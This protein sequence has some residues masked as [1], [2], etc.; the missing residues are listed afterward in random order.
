MQNFEQLGAFYLGKEFDLQA[1]Q[2]SDKLVMYDSRDL[3]THA[4]CLGMTGSGKTGLCVTLLEEAAI[5]GIPAIIIDPKGDITNLLLT[6]PDLA[7]ESFEPWINIEDAARKG[8]EPS[9]YAGH[10]AET[11]RKGL[12]Q[13]GQSQDRISLLRKSADFCIYTPGS[14]AGLPISIVASF[15]APTLDWDD[16]EELLREQIQ[17]TVS[18]LLGLVGVEADPLRSRE[19]I[20]LATLFEY[21]WRQ[22]QDLSLETLI[23]AIQKPPIRRLGVLEVDTFFPEKDRFNLAMTLNNII[24]APSFSSWTQGEPLDIAALLHTRDGKPR[25]SIFYIAHL[26]DAER[27]FFVT[28]LLE[29]LLSWVRRQSGTTSLRALLYFDE[30]FGYFPPISNPPSKKPMLTLLKQ[31]RA[32]GLGLMVCTQNPMDLDYKGLA[33]TGT[34]FIG[35]LQTDRDKIRVLDGLQSVTTEAGGGFDRQQLDEL[36]SSLGNRVFLLHNVHETEPLVFQTRWALSYLR[37]PLTRGQVRK[38]MA[39]R[40]ADNPAQAE[41]VTPVSPLTQAFSHSVVT[42]PVDT[43]K[44]TLPHDLTVGYLPLNQLNELIAK[45]PSRM[46]T[47]VFG[48]SPSDFRYLPCA[49]ILER[50]TVTDTRYRINET[51]TIGFLVHP[52]QIAPVILWDQTYRTSLDPRHLTKDP[53]PGIR[54]EA[55]PA[56]FNTVRK[57]QSLAKDASD[58]IYREHSVNLLTAPNLKLVSQAEEDER[59]FR[60]RAQQTARENR[61][62]EIDKLRQSYQ[63]KLD[64][65]QDRLAAARLDFTEDQANYERKKRD[66]LISTGEAILGFLGVLG[67]GRKG[68]IGSVLSKSGRSGA[69]RSALEKTEQKIESLENDITQL[70]EELRDEVAAISERWQSAV[71][72][73]ETL[74]IK[75]RRSDIQVVMTALVW[76]PQPR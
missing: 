70:T 75:P 39:H 9:E 64:R 29:Q 27:M 18:G 57:L 4:V 67:R 44:P 6:F 43:E 62:D 19:H 12:A 40:K 38:L 32:F 8:M 55:V 47:Q 20:L 69:A 3:T 60:A 68:R 54:H 21:F 25:H 53:E 13:W 10:I 49:Y 34:W 17:G 1:N 42:E 66:E 5:D 76:V 58:F 37:G 2:P 46:F 30:V 73:I 26:N 31:A 36:I 22:G 16:E 24:A 50:A 59:E 33:N 51:Q 15:K 48:P 56:E 71:N 45:N 28:L 23:T 65:L 14:E 11:W 72:V 61:D 35:K 52:D 63:Q 41:V 7:P 74:P